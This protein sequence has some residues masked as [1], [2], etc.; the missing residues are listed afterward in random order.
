MFTPNVPKLRKISNILSGSPVSTIDNN[1]NKPPHIPKVRKTYITFGDSPVNTIDNASI[2]PLAI[3]RTL[4]VNLLLK[5]LANGPAI[6]YNT[7]LIKK[8]CR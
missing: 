7:S 3:I 8:R 1:N 4:S 2:T 6:E 5:P